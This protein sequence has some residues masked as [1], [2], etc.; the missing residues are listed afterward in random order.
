MTSELK[1][2][3]TSLLKV[4]PACCHQSKTLPN[5]VEVQHPVIQNDGAAGAKIAVRRHMSIGGA[6]C[7]HPPGRKMGNAEDGADHVEQVYQQSSNGYVLLT[8]TTKPLSPKQVR[9]C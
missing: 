1:P 5:L 3:P 6:G 4:L 7:F 8:T 9:V 2:R